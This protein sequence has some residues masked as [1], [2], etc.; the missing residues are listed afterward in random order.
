M[1]GTRSHGSEDAGVAVYFCS[2]GKM[3]KVGKTR[4]RERKDACTKLPVS[5]VVILRLDG[6][7]GGQGQGG[8]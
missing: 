8:E 3:L 5:C 1:Q 6:G 2:G 4:E 7:E